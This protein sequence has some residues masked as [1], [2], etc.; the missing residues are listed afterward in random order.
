MKQLKAVLNRVLSVLCKA[1]FAFMTLLA[2]YQV[3]TR[4]LFNS[5]SSF[6]EELLSYSFAWLAML[7]AVLVF[8][9]RDHM[10]LSFFSD[11]VTGE[12]AIALAALTEVLIMLFASLVLIYGGSTIVVLAL[13]QVTASLGIPMG[14]VYLIMPVSGVL[15]VLYNIINL[16]E[17][18]EA[19]RA[20]KRRAV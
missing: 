3:A 8:G 20:E 18:A 14:Y 6:S 19:F 9:E 13:P 4:Y 15:I 5:P 2:V 11:K 17:L 10:R 16:T 12:K 7:A 1:L